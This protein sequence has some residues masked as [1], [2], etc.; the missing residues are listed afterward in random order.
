MSA[1][2]IMMCPPDYYAIEYEINAWMS[3]TRQADQQQAMRQWTGLRDTLRNAGVQI[4]T[5]PPVPGL[6]DI[7]F[8]ANAGLVFRDQVVLSR[9]RPEQR[10]GE[11]IHYE[12]WFRQ[13]GFDVKHLPEDVYF[14]GAGDALFCGETLIAGYR[15][16][17][18][19]RGQQKLGEML[20]CRVIPLEL[21]DPYYYHLDTCFCPLAP[22]LALYYPA[23][24]DDYGRKVL[25]EIVADLVEIPDE[26]ARCFAA[27]AVV[28]GK[29]VVTNVGCPRVHQLLAERGFEPA[30]TPL[31]EFVKAGGSAKCLT[32]RLDGEE[33]AGWKSSLEST[34]KQRFFLSVGHALRLNFRC[35]RYC[36]CLLAT[37]MVLWLSSATLA[38]GGPENLFL[39]VNPHNQDSLTIANYYRQLRQIPASNVFYLEWADSEIETDVTSFRERILKPIFDEI[40]RRKLQRQIDYVVYSAGFP[41]SVDFTSDVPDTVRFPKGSITGLTYLHEYVDQGGTA[42]LVLEP[43]LDQSRSSRANRYMRNRGPMS[44]PTRGF[45]ARYGFDLLGQ[46]QM[47]GGQRYMLSAVLGYTTGEHNPSVDEVIEYLHR[48]AAADGSL[49]LGTIYYVRNN[50]IRSQVRHNQFALAVAAL[51][52]LGVKAEILEGVVPRDKPDVQGVMIGKANFDW[53]NSGSTILPGAICDNFT[54]FGGDLRGRSQTLLSEFLRFG[55]AGASGT[56]AEPYSFH[57]KFPHPMI[58]VHYARGCTLAEAFYQSVHAPYQLLI[59]GDPLCR[60]WAQIPAVSVDGIKPGE[61]VKGR[62]VFTPSSRTDSGKA[63]RRFEVFVDG[64]LATSCEP[65]ESTNFDSAKLTEGFHELRVVAIEDSAI[66]TQGRILIPFIV[67]NQQRTIQCHVAPNATV[68]PGQELFVL[69]SSPGSSKILIYH[70]R[71]QLGTI[72]GPKGELKVDASLL[73]AGPVQLQAVGIAASSEQQHVFSA[74]VFVSVERNPRQ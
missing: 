33:A 13:H 72:E 51:R 63:V 49:P 11:Q 69:A 3:R 59:V 47:S 2:R 55:A 36:H 67:D 34:V 48:S 35:A 18:D 37:L 20:N 62:V 17:S 26:E 12:T 57:E 68:F 44:L 30:E 6:P 39:V 66:E 52:E 8:T 32:L 71:R 10:R 60:P 74:P 15:M 41:Y 65:G 25:P 21:T 45:H 70:N 23:A 64:V 50:D 38:G 31:G 19:A 54:S 4:E 40:E 22:G 73:G 46:R 61:T 58:H 42:L 5:M 9:F 14:E 7:V 56:V 53:A 16:R 1:P 29:T 24:F 43:D 27:N 28:V